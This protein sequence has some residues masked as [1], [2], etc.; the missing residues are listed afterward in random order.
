MS[1][2][3]S[4]RKQTSVELIANFALSGVSAEDV[5]SHLRFSAHDFDETLNVSAASDPVNIWLLRDYLEI[6]ARDKGL[7]PVPYRV[8]TEAGR[9]AAGRWFPLRTPPPSINE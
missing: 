1:L 5:Q 7:V 9:A 2:N 3:A 4:E 8:L 6:L